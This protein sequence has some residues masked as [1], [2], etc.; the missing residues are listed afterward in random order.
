MENPR[1][2]HPIHALERDLGL[3]HHYGAHRVRDPR[4]EQDQADAAQLK[5]GIIESTFE[6]LKV[7][8]DFELS[9]MVNS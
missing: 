7:M 6:E 3:G 8:T 2:P 4:D 1:R 5:K 9:K